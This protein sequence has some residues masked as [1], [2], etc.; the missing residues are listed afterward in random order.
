MYTTFE[1]EA[2]RKLVRGR[3][4]SILEYDSTV[5][6]ITLVRYTGVNYAMGLF[7]PRI[8]RWFRSGSRRPKTRWSTTL[9]KVRFRLAA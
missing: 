3:S 8:F 9:K 4:L 1:E 5:W 2:K 6:S 7:R